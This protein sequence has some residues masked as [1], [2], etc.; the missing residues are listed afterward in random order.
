MMAMEVLSG[1]KISYT[2][3]L[4]HLVDG[5]LADQVEEGGASVAYSS[6]NNGL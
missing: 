1:T 5:D 2:R 6:G 4:V 3:L